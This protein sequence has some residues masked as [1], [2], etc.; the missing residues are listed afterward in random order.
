MHLRGSR[1]WALGIVMVAGLSAV[2]CGPLTPPSAIQP[3]RLEAIEGSDLKRVVLTSEAAARIGIKTSAVREVEVL[4]KRTVGGEVVSVDAGALL[5][6]QTSPSDLTRIDRGQGALV[7]PIVRSG[8]GTVGTAVLPATGS[9]I[10]SARAA[11]APA[12]APGT[13]LYYVVDGR[14]HGLARGQRVVLELPLL[15]AATPRKVVPYS[16]VLFDLSGATWTYTQ[17]GSLTF[18]RQRVSIDYI[19]GD[20][21]ILTEGPAAGTEVVIVG[22]TELFGTELKVGK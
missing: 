13:A 1:Y 6:V 8:S 11:E 10:L 9:T 14:T 19:E 7:R 5:L 21:A 22:A 17:V 18:V 20:L 3:S 16:A 12:G 2:G 4:R 15:G